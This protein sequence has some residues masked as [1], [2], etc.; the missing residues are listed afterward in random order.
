MHLARN[1]KGGLPGGLICCGQAISSRCRA[2][3]EAAWKPVLPSAL[4]VSDCADMQTV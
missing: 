4:P 1:K 3:A 2:G